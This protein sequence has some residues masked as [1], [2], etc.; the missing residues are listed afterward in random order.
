MNIDALR[1][2]VNISQYGN[3]RRVADA[4]HISQPA[5]SKRIRGLEEHFGHQ[6]VE[7]SG[8][9]MRLTPAGQA[10]LPYFQ[11][12]IATFDEAGQRL[13]EPEKWQ[14]TIRLGAVDT[15]ISTWLTD[16]LDLHQQRYPNIKLEVVSAPTIELLDNLQHGNVDIALVLGPSYD[17][18]LAEVPLCVMDVAFFGACEPGN[19]PSHPRKMSPEALSEANIITFPQGSRPYIDVVQRLSQLRLA[20]M[21]SVSGCTSL[22]TMRTMAERGLG[23]ITLPRS[24]A[25]EAHLQE[26]DIGVELPSMG[27]AAVYEPAAAPSMYALTCSLAAEVAAAYARRVGSGVHVP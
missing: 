16:F 22:F 5:I 1:T 21:P 25:H 14:G 10:I 6:L 18:A 7:R 20:A 15:I 19:D 2:L 3:Y 27:F 24:M 26:L 23:V 8:A 4:M 13:N 17:R 12:I 9:F 11:R